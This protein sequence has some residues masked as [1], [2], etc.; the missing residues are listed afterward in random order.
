[1]ATAQY[2]TNQTSAPSIEPV[3]RTEA[4]AQCRYTDTD[5]DV[6][7]DNLIE[8]ARETVENI[9]GQQLITATWEL[10]LD[11]FPDVIELPYPPLQSVTSIKYYDTSDALQTLSASDYRTDIYTVPGRIEPAYGETW[12]T[13]RP[14][15]ATITVT[16][17]AGYG[18]TAS[19]VPQTLRLAIRQLV[20]HWFTNREPVAM[21]RSLSQ[22]EIPTT[23]DRLL[24]N[25][26]VVE[27]Y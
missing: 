16:Y 22:V 19:T 24:W 12:P 3:T 13:V 17:V 14:Q 27:L 2:S 5:E 18:A 26:K 23:V 6:Y 25:N 8:M 11:E 7:F 9:T 21:G 4:K 20:A 1:M 10:R 15:N